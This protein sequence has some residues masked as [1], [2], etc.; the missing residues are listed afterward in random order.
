M[1]VRQAI[2]CATR[3]E[4]ATAGNVTATKLHD[5]SVAIIGYGHAVYAV[6]TDP[7]S[8]VLFT[9]WD[10]YS[11][12]TSKHMNVIRDEVPDNQLEFS[13]AQPKTEDILCLCELRTFDVAKP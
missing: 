10:G 9:G 11:P 1:S 3:G 4:V 8:T 7:P 13:D 6:V 2:S 12:T 5:G